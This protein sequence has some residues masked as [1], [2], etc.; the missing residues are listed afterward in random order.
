[1]KERVLYF[2]YIK[3]SIAYYIHEIDKNRATH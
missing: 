2:R 1:M 3:Y